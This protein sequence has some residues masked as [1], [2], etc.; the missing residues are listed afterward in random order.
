MPT[1]KESVYDILDYDPECGLVE[2]I[3]TIGLI[4]LIITN[5]IAV[6][7][8][9][10]PGIGT[11]YATFFNVF[12]VFSVGIFTIE[13]LLRLW[14]ITVDLRY[15]EPVRGRLRFMVTPF[16]LIDVLAVLPFYVPFFLPVDLRTLRLFRLLRVL[17]LFKTG[18]YSQA[19]DIFIRVFRNK[20]AEL[21]VTVAVA[22]VLL[23]I[24][25]SLMY[26]VE[27]DV[28]PDKFPSIIGTMW[29]AMAT[30]TTIGYGDVTPITPLGK[31][32]SG[33]IA[34]LGIALFGLPAGIFASGFMEEIQRKT[35]HPVICPHCGKLIDEQNRER[36]T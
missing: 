32:L 19:F 11:E 14:S 5:V 8:Q 10:E 34:V 3:V 9:T 30:L 15:R 27:H 35:Q 4:I 22:L 7:L 29:W 18:R 1:L 23:I 12:E 26:S 36:E 20:Q 25:S 33:C 31:L 24:S 6:I 13:Y 21:L 17:R 2:K 16:A 28:Q